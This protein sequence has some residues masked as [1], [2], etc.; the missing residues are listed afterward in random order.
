MLTEEEGTCQKEQELGA[1]ST[2][3]DEFDESMFSLDDDLFGRG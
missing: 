1:T 3:V 2:G